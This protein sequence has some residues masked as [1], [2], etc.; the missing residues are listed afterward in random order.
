MWCVS[1]ALCM[2]MVYVSEVC[3]WCVHVCKP[4]YMCMVYV[5]MVYVCVRCEMCVVGLERWLRG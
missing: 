4:V 3:V 2:C 1:V 5:C